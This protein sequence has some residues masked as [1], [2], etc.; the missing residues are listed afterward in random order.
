MIQTQ[1]PIDIESAEIARKKTFGQ[2]IDLCLEVG[3]LEPKQIQTDLKVDKGQYSRWKDGQEGIKWEK[4]QCLQ[5]RCGN[6]APVLWMFYRSGFDLESARR[7]ET[8]VERENRL[9]REENAALRR[10]LRTTP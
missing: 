8:E 9:L 10:A 6:A 5:Q 4:L 2:A 1:I 3:G 7:R